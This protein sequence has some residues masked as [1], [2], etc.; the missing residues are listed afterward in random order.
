MEDVF[1]IDVVRYEDE[2]DLSVLAQ[3]VIDADPGCWTAGRILLCQEEL[4]GVGVKSFGVAK[5]H[6]VLESRTFFVK[7]VDGSSEI[8]CQLNS[9]A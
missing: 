3:A 4:I 1:A 6:R 8:L 9:L 7:G 5:L 2:F